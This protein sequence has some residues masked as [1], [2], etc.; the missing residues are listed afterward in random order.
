MRVLDCEMNHYHFEGLSDTTPSSMD[1]Q[2]E[3]GP[4]I[5]GYS[6]EYVSALLVQLEDTLKAPDAW[7]RMTV[8]EVV[9]VAETLVR[10]DV[11]DISILQVIDA[12]VVSYCTPDSLDAR[13]LSK[14]L[15]SY[16]HLGYL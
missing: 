13:N 16:A 3:M 1:H 2:L 6:P 7:D 10:L 14:L 9:A 11:K 5:I 12:L 8:D 4:P 15:N